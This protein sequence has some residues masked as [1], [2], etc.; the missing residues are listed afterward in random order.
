MVLDEPQTSV[1]RVW[2]W[3]RIVLVLV[4]GVL[5]GIVI[6]VVTIVWPRKNELSRLH[7]ESQYFAAFNPLADVQS[8]SASTAELVESHDDQNMSRSRVWS[9]SYV[10]KCKAASA[11]QA[12]TFE[13][14]LGA[15]QTAMSRRMSASNQPRRAQIWTSRRGARTGNGWQDHTAT[16]NYQDGLAA[17]IVNV[18]AIGERDE[19][20]FNIWIVEQ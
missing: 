15:L 8:V 14:L 18:S 16:M 7:H 9:R 10:I 12:A 19:L 11:E 13:R 1:S 6:A 20:T 5:L 2:G 3:L 17:G 4:V